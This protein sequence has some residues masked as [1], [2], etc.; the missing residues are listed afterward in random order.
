MPYNK[1]TQKEY[2]EN[3]LQKKSGFK[4]KMGNS[5]LKWDP[6]GWKEKRRRKWAKED[7]EAQYQD[8]LV[9]G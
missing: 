5:P 4:M 9:R 8:S 3:P 7:Q 6:F 2:G 1:S